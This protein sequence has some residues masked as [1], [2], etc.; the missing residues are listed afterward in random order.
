MQL[1]S[2]FSNI[3][4]LLSIFFIGVNLVYLY[5]LAV[6]SL[7]TLNQPTS[8]SQ[9]YYLAIAIPAHNEESVIARTV[10]SILAADY[11]HGKLHV[12]VVADHCSDNTADNARRANATVYEKDEGPIGGK[13]P[14]LSWLFH[15][16][17][18]SESHYD[19]II[20]FDAD[21]IVDPRFFKIINARLYEGW[22]AI[23]GK[24]IIRNSQ[25]G[26]FPA[27]S[28]AMFII[29]NR[30]QNLGR[31]N[32]GLSA[33]NMGD[34]IC[35]RAEILQQ[36]GW[37]QG[38]T[39]DYEFRQQLLIAG[40]RIIYEPTAIGYG[41]A[42]A[43]WQEAQAQ[44]TRWLI[45][46]K[47]A[48]RKNAKMMFSI[49]VKRRNSPLIDAALQGILPSFSTLTIVCGAFMLLG[50]LLDGMISSW[51]VIGYTIAFVLYFLYPFIVLSFE[52]AP[53]RAYLII[54]TGPAY[55]LWR[56][57]IILSSYFRNQP[58]RWIRTPRHE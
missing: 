28:W 32:L 18:E 29:D 57:W 19:A 53:I 48:S 10:S 41:D 5:L 45:G 23:Q 55:I 40:I 49:G 20:I 30:T 50:W 58:N 26:W 43:N 38:L 7:V 27:L 1:L 52:R 3:I 34:S 16:I 33:K 51:L 8:T 39:E 25:K 47:Q 4:Y 24:H 2:I 36:L 6:A 37:G 35:I 17:F 14:A 12:Y 15:K 46:A 31:S 56:T 44:R 13:G 11:P 21:T 9:Y 54:I 42:A 22:Q